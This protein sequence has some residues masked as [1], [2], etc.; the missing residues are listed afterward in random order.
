M[1]VV[2]RQGR[3]EEEVV[4]APATISMRSEMQSCQFSHVELSRQFSHDVEQSRQ[5]SHVWLSHPVNLAMFG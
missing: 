1:K 5:F 4:V 2:G 3:M